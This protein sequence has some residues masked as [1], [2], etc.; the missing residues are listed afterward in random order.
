MYFFYSPKIKMLHFVCFSAQIIWNLLW[1]VMQQIHLHAVECS[2]EACRCVWRTQKWAAAEV[3][4]CGGR[5]EPV[6]VPF[7]PHCLR[8]GQVSS[9]WASPHNPWWWNGIHAQPSR[10]FSLCSVLFSSIGIVYRY[11]FPSLIFIRYLSPSFALMWLFCVSV[12]K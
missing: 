7:H 6:L 8:D 3:R 9:Q 11:A 1:G 12:L 5:R 10:A 2:T 4:D